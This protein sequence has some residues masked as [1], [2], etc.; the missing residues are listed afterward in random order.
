MSEIYKVLGYGLTDVQRVNGIIEDPRFNSDSPFV[1]YDSGYDYNDVQSFLEFIGPTN[2]D[3]ETVI[4]TYDVLS[5]QSEDKL[6]QISLMNSF[7][8]HDNVF[9]II[10]VHCQKDWLRQDDIIDYEEI[11]AHSHNDI[12]EPIITYAKNFNIW[13]YQNW[14]NKK[15]GKELTTVQSTHW[16][17]L[18]S[19]TSTKNIHKFK[20]NYAHKLGFDSVEDATKNLMPIPPMDVRH[21]S[22]YGALLNDDTIIYDFKPFVYTYYV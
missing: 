13:P 3:I 8:Q 21:L 12:L 19:D 22:E 15:T 2:Y 6:R 17:T 20:L 5:S 16:L 11:R 18:L 10:P 7:I 4:S 1:T 14:L 9:M